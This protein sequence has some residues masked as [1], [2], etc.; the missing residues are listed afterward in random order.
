MASEHSKWR[1]WFRQRE[2]VGYRKIC[3]T[4]DSKDDADAFVERMSGMEPVLVF[5]SIESVDA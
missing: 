4:F 2:G 1:V 5:D 3:R